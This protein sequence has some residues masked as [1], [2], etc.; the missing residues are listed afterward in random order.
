[1][2]DAQTSI[3]LPSPIFYFPVSRRPFEFSPGLRKLDINN[4]KDLREQLFQFDSQWFDYQ[5]QKLHAL[6]QNFSRYCCQHE[7]QEST[8]RAAEGFLISQLLDN[9]SNLFS[10]H[11]NGTKPQL[12]NHLSHE[13][14]QLESRQP[15]QFFPSET[16]L[17]SL[18]RQLQEDVSIIQFYGESDYIAYL[19]LCFPNHWAAEEKIGQSFIKSHMTVPGMEKINRQATPLMQSFI[20]GSPMERFTWGITTDSILDKHPSNLRQRLHGR[21]LSDFYLRIER[22]VLIG[23]PKVQ[24]VIF[25]IRSYH[26]PLADLTT[27]EQQHLA[28]SINTMPDAIRRYKGLDSDAEK[29]VKLLQHAVV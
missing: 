28:Y 19:H 20:S 22:Q 9:Y 5:Q 27:D 7:L 6:N 15:S 16:L 4:K 14:L 25:L 23:L 18:C 3:P 24:A 17:D 8:R 11:H 13:S 29:L 12:L 2:G 1:M 26:R 10:I 21:S